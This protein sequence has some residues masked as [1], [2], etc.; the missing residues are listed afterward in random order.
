VISPLNSFLMTSKNQPQ[1]L[2]CTWHI[3]LILSKIPFYTYIPSISL[4]PAPRAVGAST[5]RIFGAKKECR[6]RTAEKLDD[7]SYGCIFN[8]RRR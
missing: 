8:N 3:S 6:E 2:P 4:C 7:L 1:D 5:A